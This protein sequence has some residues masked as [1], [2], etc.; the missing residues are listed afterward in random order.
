[1]NEINRE[2]DVVVIGSGVSG[3]AAAVTAAEA[4]LKVMVFEKQ[5]S[6]GGTSNFFEGIFAVESDMQRERYIDY[7]RD[8]AFKNIMEYGHW[9]AN[10]RLVRAYVDQTAETV[11]WLKERGVEFPDVTINM[12]NAPRGYHIVKGGGAVVV[13]ALIERAKENGAVLKTGTP[14]IKII[15]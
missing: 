11:D 5:R 3:L 13:T 7:T 1:M 9:K 14:V 6:F 2:T 15:K 10:A 12:P 4:G 8:Q